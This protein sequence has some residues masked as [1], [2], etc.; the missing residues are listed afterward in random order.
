MPRLVALLIVLVVAGAHAQDPAA[1]E[2]TPPPVPA[3]DGVKRLP[4]TAGVAGRVT[5]APDGAPLARAVVDMMCADMRNGPL[6]IETGDDGRFEFRGLS[7][8]GCYVTAER[9]GF[10]D[11]A[12]GHDVTLGE[13]STA[14]VEITLE[15]AG[16]ITGRVVDELGEPMARVTV[17]AV[18]RSRVGTQAIMQGRETDDEGRFRLFDLAPGHYLVRAEPMRG[19]RLT[20][21]GRRTFAY[22]PGFAPGVP[23]AASAQVVTIGQSR[24][25]GGVEIRLA[26][27]RTYHLSGTVLNSSGRPPRGGFLNVA[28]DD[29]VGGRTGEGVEIGPGGAFLIEGLAP[30]EYTL[31]VGYQSPEPQPDI[32]VEYAR[33]DLVLADDV[34]GLAIVTAPTATVHGE[35][36]IEGARAQVSL[37]A[38]LQIIAL[39][40]DARR[41]AD[42]V[43][44]PRMAEVDENRRFT[45]RAVAGPVV[46][47]PAGAVDGL[48]LDRVVYR[49]EDV[50][51]VPIELRSSAAGQVDV[52]LVFTNRAARVTGRVTDANGHPVAGA[53]VVA[54]SEPRSAGVLQNAGDR[55]APA[56]EQ[57]TYVLEGLTAERYLLVALRSRESWSEDMYERS[58]ELATPVTLLDGDVRTVNLELVALPP[59]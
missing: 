57:G 52:L 53:R 12:G 22:A 11:P 48:W 3:R 8:G 1:V 51:D 5:T 21:D 28:S 37:P 32:D 46:L 16:V 18:R 27:Q 34:D 47:R 39:P 49:G 10:V 6:S 36:V 15:P 41:R 56:G 55:F 23:D 13:S 43:A 40:A 45:L 7:P 14:R 26:R 17:S 33:Q 24:D 54:F 35:I 44:G 42:P 58:A 4:A 38:D 29:G 31:E 30:G 19:R 9:R 25:V 50:T 59:P 2:G 20:D